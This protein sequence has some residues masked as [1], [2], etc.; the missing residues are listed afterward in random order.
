M[1]HLISNQ[2]HPV[3]VSTKVNPCE[4]LDQNNPNWRPKSYSRNPNAYKSELKLPSINQQTGSETDFKEKIDLKRIY[5]SNSYK[6]LRKDYIVQ[7]RG[8]KEDR[9]PDINPALSHL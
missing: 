1:Q 4:K 2:K 8:P 6:N 3:R 9:D 7:K 5:K